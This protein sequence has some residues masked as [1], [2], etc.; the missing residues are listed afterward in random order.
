MIGDKFRTKDGGLAYSSSIETQGE[1]YFLGLD[2]TGTPYFVVHQ[3]REGRDIP[4]DFHSLRT[5]GAQLND[6]DIGAAVHALALTQWH[7]SHQRCAKCG[8]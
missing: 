5:I 6:L 3:N 4:G 2:E 1:R 8:D 7:E